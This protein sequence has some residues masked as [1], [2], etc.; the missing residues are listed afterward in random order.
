MSSC[1]FALIG[2]T[3]FNQRCSRHF[4]TLA[5]HLSGAQ[6]ISAVL[7]PS[8]FV[9]P[10]FS[11]AN[12]SGNSASSSNSSGSSDNPQHIAEAV[13]GDAAEGAEEVQQEPEDSED[14]QA[15]Q[16][17]W[18]ITFAAKKAETVEAA[19]IPLKELDDVAREDVQAAI[20]DA[21]ANPAVTR[22]GRPRKTPVRIIK[23]L[24]A[25]ELPKYFHA[26]PR[27]SSEPSLQAAN[28]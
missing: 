17:V 6:D 27:G 19:T 8:S 26:V 13:A 12:A 10:T 15:Q 2:C 14:P 23:M 20:L 4:A 3:L 18:I 21:F 22:G 28:K 16:E 24:I 1:T 9:A 7:P 25:M 11:F 5:T